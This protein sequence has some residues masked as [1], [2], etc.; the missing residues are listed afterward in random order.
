MQRIITVL[1]LIGIAGCG[2]GSGTGD[3]AASDS[4]SG[5]K[6]EDIQRAREIANRI[7]AQN[8]A[9][10][11]AQENNPTETSGRE[12]S[13]RDDNR[14]PTAIVR[15][16]DLHRVLAE[17]E[18]V[19]PST[20][21]TTASSGNVIVGPDLSVTIRTHDNWQR[22]D[23]SDVRIETEFARVYGDPTAS[24]FVILSNATK[25]RSDDDTPFRGL[26]Y[27][28]YGV[29]L[30]SDIF[31]VANFDDPDLTS[32]GSF[33]L[34]RQTS[35]ENMPQTG[36]ARY[37]GAAFAVQAGSMDGA[38]LLLSGDVKLDVDFGTQS[39]QGQ[40]DLVNSERLPV[41]SILLSSQPIEGNRFTHSNLKTT[42]GE[43]GNLYGNFMGPNAE[44]V[45]GAFRFEGDTTI[46]G[47]FGAGLCESC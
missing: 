35:P 12:T 23:L 43:R 9:A 40:I 47:A 25:L 1:V 42:T 36:T 15:Q 10:Q 39:A 46:T 3:T 26:D 33:L 22:F 5:W 8:R 32:Q 27:T 24:N 31:A 29:W 17:P 13:D 19:Q 44:E 11:A 38:G 2:G 7:S 21:L 6:S 45:G 14:N 34:G 37:A 28:V 16:T 30:E 18:N 4:A 20:I 41:T